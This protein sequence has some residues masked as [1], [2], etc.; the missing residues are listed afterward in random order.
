MIWISDYENERQLKWEKKPFQCLCTH[1][2]C[3]SQETMVVQSGA[4]RWSVCALRKKTCVSSLYDNS[5]R[6][7]NTAH[8]RFGIHLFLIWHQNIRVRRMW[9]PDMICSRQ[10]H[11]EH[12]SK[13]WDILLLWKSWS[14]EKKDSTSFLW[15]AAFC[16]RLVLLIGNNWKKHLSSN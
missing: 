9:V 7:I 13:I 10:K 14:A 16:R 12:L 6:M 3:F 1:S 5:H 2:I 11:G 4:L 8:L 15:A